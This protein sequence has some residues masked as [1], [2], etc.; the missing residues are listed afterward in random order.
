MAKDK[1][2]EINKLIEQEESL[3]LKLE[4]LCDVKKIVA[5]G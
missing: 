5:L 2:S 4:N 1:N 3:A